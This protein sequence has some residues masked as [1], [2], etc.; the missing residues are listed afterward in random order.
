MPPKRSPKEMALNHD[1][2]EEINIKE[3]FKERRPF[4]FEFIQEQLLLIWVS[5]L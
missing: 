4:S 3:I 1:S 2:E 5:L